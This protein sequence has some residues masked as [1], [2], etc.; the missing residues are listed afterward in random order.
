[1]TALPEVLGAVAVTAAVVAA[2]R[3][4]LF[5]PRLGVLAPGYPAWWYGL[6]GGRRAAV[7]AA[8]PV[9]GAMTGLAFQVQAGWLPASGTLA[10]L[11]AVTVMS[12]TIRAVTRR[13]GR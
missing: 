1:M 3:A 2:H 4:L 10:G 6:T 8:L 7:A 11:A 9:A 12:R 13:K 5:S